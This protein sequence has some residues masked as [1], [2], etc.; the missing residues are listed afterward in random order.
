[1]LF[2]YKGDLAREG[3]NPRM[4]FDGKRI[5][6]KESQGRRGANS[7]EQQHELQMNSLANNRRTTANNRR[8]RSKQ[9]KPVGLA[10]GGIYIERI[11]C[12]RPASSGWSCLR[13]LSAVAVR[14]AWICIARSPGAGRVSALETSP[15]LL[16]D[17]PSRVQGEGA[18]SAE[19]AAATERTRTV[20][21]RS[22]KFG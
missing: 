1:M 7:E 16:K 11:I 15:F 4:A 3:W 12:V 2:E 18:L 22:A 6:W 13:S 19:E 8:R 14:Q 20:H 17:C 9:Q 5:A 21:E 10:R